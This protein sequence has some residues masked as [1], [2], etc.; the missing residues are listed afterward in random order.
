VIHEDQ[1][2][3]SEWGMGVKEEG[4]NEKREGEA[5]MGV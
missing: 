2:S 1:K 4:E 5:Q 3:E